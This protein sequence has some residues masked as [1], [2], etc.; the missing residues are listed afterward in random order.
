MEDPTKIPES[1]EV[2]I[3]FPRESEYVIGGTHFIV[4]AH[5]DE[6]QEDLKTKVGRLLKKEVGKMVQST[7]SD[8]PKK[9]V[10]SPF[11]VTRAVFIWRKMLYTDA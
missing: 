9:R 8:E 3:E 11:S 5:Y 2:I 6:T 4:T 1:E 10:P 7:M